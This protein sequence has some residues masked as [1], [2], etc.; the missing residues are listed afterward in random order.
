MNIIKAFDRIAL[1]LAILAV[2]PG[3]FIGLAISYHMLNAAQPGIETSAA[4][5]DLS[6][7]WWKVLIYI[8]V[9]ILG[10]VVSFIV[11]LFGIRGAARGIAR[12]F[13]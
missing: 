5:A 3:G 7:I 1:V 6:L 9:S 12:I 4:Q 8:S 11:V 13:R 2:F 10:A